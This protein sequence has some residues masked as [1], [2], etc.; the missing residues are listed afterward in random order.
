[1]PLAW[2]TQLTCQDCKLIA[3]QRSSAM[4]PHVALLRSGGTDTD[5]HAA[6]QELLH[7]A[8]NEH[9]IAIAQAGTIPL[10]VPLLLHGNRGD[11]CKVAAIQLLLSLGKHKHT[12]AI[13]QA[14]AIPPLVTILRTDG[15]DTLK[16]A[17]T[18]M[19]GL[20]SIHNYASATAI[21][22]AGAIDPLMKLLGAGTSY[23]LR[24]AATRVLWDVASRDDNHTNTT[25]YILN[26]GILNSLVAMIDTIGPAALKHEAI[27]V[28][29]SIFHRGHANA[30][31]QAGAIP[32]FLRL[33]KTAKTDKLKLHAVCAISEFARDDL[34]DTY[35]HKI[36]GAHAIPIFVT[37]LGSRCGDDNDARSL[38][39][40]VAYLLR[41]LA[42]SGYTK[43]IEQARAR[44]HWAIA[45][46]FCN[47]HACAHFWYAHT[48]KQL[49]APGCKWAE[50][51]RG[52]F[53]AD[54]E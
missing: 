48:C 44:H 2:L 12:H 40:T 21:V 13:V 15:T 17:A 5:T 35:I 38:Q 27:R 47:M 37:Q 49:C 29:R 4:A 43:P 51:D 8:N 3:I 45:R 16:E 24:V 10:L 9:A 42:L 20:L 30:V 19:L 32:V 25:T 52:A 39:L 1:M 31:E 33:L 36:A 50:R 18:H 34:D 28:L 23:T 22:Q 41:K 46:A 7:L 14:G 26:A 11:A 53:E 6:I 54:F